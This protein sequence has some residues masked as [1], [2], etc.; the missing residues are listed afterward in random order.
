MKFGSLLAEAVASSQSGSAP[1][2]AA[3]RPLWVLVV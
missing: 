2:I 1:A 3:A